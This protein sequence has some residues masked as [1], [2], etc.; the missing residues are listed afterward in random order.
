MIGKTDRK[1]I[2]D[3]DHTIFQNCCLN[4][5]TMQHTNY[6]WF[7][8]IQGFCVLYIC[9]IAAKLL[10]FSFT[11]KSNGLFGSRPNVER[12]P[13]LVFGMGPTAGKNMF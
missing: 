12:H 4:K 10:G 2:P 8:I 6:C 5:I 3:D 7:K 1:A 9:L 11:N 13:I